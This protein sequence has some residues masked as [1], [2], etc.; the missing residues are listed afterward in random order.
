MFSKRGENKKKKNF[1][2]RRIIMLGMQKREIKKILVCIAIMIVAL[3]IAS[4][5]SGCAFNHRGET[6][7]TFLKDMET[8]SSG[9]STG[10]FKRPARD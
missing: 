8:S 4:V 6:S 5:V 10:S 3:A 1:L 9:T 2:F 7:M